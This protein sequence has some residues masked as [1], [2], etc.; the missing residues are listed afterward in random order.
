MKTFSEW[1]ADKHPE[2]IEE[3]WAKN[4]VTAGLLGAASLGAMPNFAHAADTN[5]RSSVTQN[6]QD[7]DIIE[8]NGMVYFKGSATPKDNSPKA[9]MDA[10][11]V[12]ENKIQLKA[13]RYFESKGGKRDF[14]PPGFKEMNK[15]D[16][17]SGK[18]D[19]IVWAWKIEK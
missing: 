14:V 12:A 13:A 7:K 1:V 2:S 8:K 16:F 5:N 15:S 19:Y 18:S 4:L 10:L 9:R 17:L 3:S 6:A 11:R